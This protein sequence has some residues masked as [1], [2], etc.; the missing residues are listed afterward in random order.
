MKVI[1]LI[2]IVSSLTAISAYDDRNM[3]ALLRDAMEDILSQD[4]REAAYPP[5]LSEREQELE[6]L[7]QLMNAQ[8]DEAELE[9]EVGAQ[10]EEGIN[11]MLAKM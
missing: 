1:S 8:E 4:A 3:K 7:H 5:K 9:E 10:Q 6:F 2:F 11:I